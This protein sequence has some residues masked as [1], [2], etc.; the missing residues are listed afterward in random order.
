[1]CGA[2]ILAAMSCGVGQEM[3]VDAT[4]GAATVSWRGPCTLVQCC[5]ST[6]WARAKHSSSWHGMKIYWLIGEHGPSHAR[7]R[8]TSG[9]RKETAP[10]YGSMCKKNTSRNN[11]FAM[12]AYYRRMRD[13]ATRVIHRNRGELTGIWSYGTFLAVISPYVS[14]LFD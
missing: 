3:S 8:C 1:M 13:L 6:F 10:W 14:R 11:H 4:S 7:M 12:G 9:I 5:A 2:W